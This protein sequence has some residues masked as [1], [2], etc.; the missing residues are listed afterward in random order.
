M[1]QLS[2][3]TDTRWHQ[4]GHFQI[5]EKITPE[6]RVWQVRDPIDVSPKRGF[7]TYRDFKTK[8]AAT[9]FMDMKYPDGPP[10]PSERTEPIE[11]KGTA[12]LL[13]RLKALPPGHPYAIAASAAGITL[14]DDGGEWSYPTDYDA[15]AISDMAIMFQ[16]T[17]G[18]VAGIR[19]AWEMSG[20]HPTAGQIT[21]CWENPDAWDLVDVDREWFSE[22]VAA[23]VPL[24]G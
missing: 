15:V 12:E 3:A 6:G 18:P 23:R 7:G 2:P 9:E 22:Q 24:A 20:P 11:T 5:I 21:W 4:Y 16:R 17:D 8:K 19:S 13:Q 10:K 1:T 14:D